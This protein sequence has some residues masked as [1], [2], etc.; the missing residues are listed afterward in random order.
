MLLDDCI[1]V[2]RLPMFNLFL[3]GCPPGQ[4]SGGAAGKNGRKTLCGFCLA[5][6]A[7]SSLSLSLPSPSSLPAG[8]NRKRRLWEKRKAE[9]GAITPEGGHVKSRPPR[10]EQCGIVEKKKKEHGVERRRGLP[11]FPANFLFF[12][13][14]RKVAAARMWALQKPKILVMRQRRWPGKTAGSFC[15]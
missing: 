9:H 2:P 14:S 7:L 6:R 4:D 1:C 13:S 15:V 8:A 5:S 11:F 3:F 10:Q 12:F